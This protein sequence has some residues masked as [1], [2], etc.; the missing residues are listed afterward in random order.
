MFKNYFKT[1][2]RGLLRG[3]SFSLINIFSLA[4]GMA[5]AVLI[6]APVCKMK[7]VLIN[8]MPTKTTYEVYGQTLAQTGIHLQS[9][10]FRN[11][12]ALR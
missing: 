12:W 10:L 9:L 2:W 11:H 6:L 1:A 5:G 4:N 8:F 7:S 3:K